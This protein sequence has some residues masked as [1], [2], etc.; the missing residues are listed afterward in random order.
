M[1]TAALQHCSS[2]SMLLSLLYGSEKQACARYRTGREELFG[3]R[4]FK[5]KDTSVKYAKYESSNFH[6]HCVEALSSANVGEMLDQQAASNRNQNQEYLLRLLSSVRFLACQGL[7]LRGD[8][9]HEE[10]SNLH[11]L[12]TLRCEDSS[13]IAEFLHKKQLK[14]ISPEVQ[15]EFLAITMNQILRDI[16]TSLQGGIYYAVMVD[17]TTDATNKEQVVLMVCWVDDSFNAQEEFI[18]LQI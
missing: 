16:A 14:Y 7:P 4:F 8:G 12:R 11:Q 17:E 3:Q 9:D 13:V 5:L 2:C 1:E 18:G 6:K 15:N 10:S